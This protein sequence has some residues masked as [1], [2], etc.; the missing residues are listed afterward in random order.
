VGYVIAAYALVV[1]ALA[2]YGLSLARER[3][4]LVSSL[5]ATLRA[6]RRGKSNQS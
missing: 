4:R 6:S 1:V 3:R 5:G 2:A